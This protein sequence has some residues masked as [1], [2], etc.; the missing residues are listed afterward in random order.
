MAFPD[1][2][3]YDSLRRFMTLRLSACTIPLPLVPPSNSVSVRVGWGMCHSSF[4]S[5]IASRSTASSSSGLTSMSCCAS[6]GCRLS[7]NSEALCALTFSLAARRPRAFALLPLRFLIPGVVSRTASSSSGSMLFASLPPSSFVG[8][9]YASE[10]SAGVLASSDASRAA[11]RLLCNRLRLAGRPEANSSSCSL[12]AMV[13]SSSAGAAGVLAAVLVSS[14]SNPG[15]KRFL[16]DIGALSCASCSGI[17]SASSISSSSSSASISTSPKLDDVFKSCRPIL[18]KGVIFP[19]L[20][21]NSRCDSPGRRLLAASS[22]CPSLSSSAI[23]SSA[24][25]FSSRHFSLVIWLP[26]PASFS[27]SFRSWPNI[28]S[29]VFCVFSKRFLSR[30][31]A[32]SSWRGR[33]LDL[34][35]GRSP[36]RGAKQTMG[37]RLA[38][39]RAGQWCRRVYLA[40]STMEDHVVDQDRK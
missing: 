22:P 6:S 30:S 19:V 31:S 17:S 9:T 10:S 18:E 20:I 24:C 23:L 39:W 2:A 26:K 11:C 21:K 27:L 35:R 1:Y 32:C 36:D 5:G 12:R 29:L 14:C 25:F 37:V 4:L 7:P 15:A 34:V 13:S 40:H 8:G 38:V 16:C 28:R 33:R 3:I